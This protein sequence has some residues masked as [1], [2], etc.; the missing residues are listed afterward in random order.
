MLLTVIAVLLLVLLTALPDPREP[1]L[2]VAEG[3]RVTSEEP[4]GPDGGREPGGD[5]GDGVRPPAGTPAP[6]PETD[7]DLDRDTGED[8]RGP[9][10]DAGSAELRPDDGPAAGGD[11][12]D[13]NLV[14]GRPRIAVV[15][16]DVGYNLHQLEPFLEVDIPMTM[17]ILPKLTYSADAARRAADAGKEV[18]LHLPL[19][20][21]GGGNPGPGTIGV[22]DDDE[23]VLRSL[24]ENL[25]SVPGAVGANN[26]MGSRA[27]GD[28]RIMNLILEQIRERGLFFLDSR[29]TADSVV[30][31]VARR[32]NVPYTE[33]HVFLDNEQDAESIDAALETAAEIAKAGGFAVV[34]GHVWTDILPRLLAAWA[35]TLRDAGFEFVPLSDILSARH[36]GIGD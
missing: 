11:R 18:I 19:E 15:I 13:D 6:V 27:T 33:R 14:T 21:I 31:S 17:A 32:L 16:D 36:A 2:A 20:A 4:E 29:T 8:E 22:G 28:E 35:A 23:R 10:R 7:A 3:G 12:G 26:H 5:R 25:T 9:S 24:E 1:D 30:S 34:I